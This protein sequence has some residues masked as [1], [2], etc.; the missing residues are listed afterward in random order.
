[1]KR[2]TF[3][4]PLL[5]VA[6]AA[7]ML[8]GCTLSTS[9]GGGGAT[10]A[11]SSALPVGIPATGQV[12]FPDYLPF[13][14]ANFSDGPAAFGFDFNFLSSGETTT[15]ARLALIRPEGG[16]KWSRTQVTAQ[17][18]YAIGAANIGR[19]QVV[20]GEITFI[21]SQ[22]PT[23]HPFIATSA[24]GRTFNTEDVSSTLFGTWPA[25][26]MDVGRTGALGDASAK[27]IV[28]GTT[29]TAPKAVLGN[30]V[31][32]KPIAFLSANGTD[33]APAGELPLPAGV[34]GAGASAV[35]FAGPGTAFPGVLVTGTGWTA[36]AKMGRRTVSI[37]WQST[38]QGASF[39]VVS[40][41]AFSIDGRNVA[42]MYLA[43]DKDTI[44]VA[45]VANIT[46]AGAGGQ[47]AAM[48]WTI[49]AQ[50]KVIRRIDKLAPKRDT[51][52]TALLARPGGGFISATQEHDV[53][54]SPTNPGVKPQGKP[55]AHVW[56]SP[57]GSNWTELGNDAIP[58]IDEAMVIPGMAESGGRVTFFGEDVKQLSTFWVV[59]SSAIK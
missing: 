42:S 53:G 41:D 5:A 26:F 39:K 55:V 54:S 30:P 18:A 20:V 9:K 8:G 22:G 43:A 35:T 7:T 47:Y 49:T 52:T 34:T 17:P 12:G 6:F 57:D 3:V 4:V 2:L 15:A 11:G 1:M 13:G 38:D 59:E 56:A 19:T 37:L 21:T 29:V 51:N 36:D 27:F 16:Q 44:V 28:V 40:A 31:A 46:S 48:Q 33:W 25:Q 23:R 45:G 14:A 58:H 24:D 50:G 10:A 32:S